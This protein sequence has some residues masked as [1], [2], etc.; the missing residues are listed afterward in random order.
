M[1][2]AQV[3]KDIVTFCDEL[4]RKQY[5]GSD[6]QKKELH[7]SLLE[8]AAD[9]A[10]L[11]RYSLNDPDAHLIPTEQR[12]DM[13]GLSIDSPSGYLRKLGITLQFFHEPQRLYPLR[14][15]LTTENKKMEIQIQPD[16]K[17]PML[18]KLLHLK[19]QNPGTNK[20]LPGQLYGK[21]RVPRKRK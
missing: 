6:E 13:I 9:Y 4:H 17:L 8:L 18:N 10:R 19:R 5:I 1:L 16:K 14:L 11:P 2:S 15:E 21:S 3:E 7:S 12:F 20:G